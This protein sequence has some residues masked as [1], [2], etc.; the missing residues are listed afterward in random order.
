[1]EGVRK[2]TKEELLKGLTEEQ[3]EI[4]RLSYEKADSTLGLPALI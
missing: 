3:L 4:P 2:F 1:M